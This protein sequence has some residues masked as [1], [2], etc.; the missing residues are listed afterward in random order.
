M[1]AF[2]II[3]LLV[4]CSVFGEEKSYDLGNSLSIHIEEKAFVIDEWEIKYCPNSKVV[5]LINGSSPYGVDG[6]TPK[7]YLSKLTAI[8]NGKKFVLDSSNMFNA[9]GTRPL[10]YPGAVKYFAGICQSKNWCTLRGLFSDAAGS[11]VAEWQI[12]QGIPERTIITTSKDV[13]SLFIKNIEP[14]VYY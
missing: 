13:V 7:T 1:R 5:C 10:E 12:R 9:W 6:T 2:S 8:I 3:I 11:F 14:P 4:S